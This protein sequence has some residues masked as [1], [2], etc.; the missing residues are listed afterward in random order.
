MPETISN[1]RIRY[2]NGSNSR[3]YGERYVH[4]KDINQTD[5][6][7]VLWHKLKKKKEICQSY[8]SRKYRTS[9]AIFCFTIFSW[10]NPRHW[11]PPPH[12]KSLL[13]KLNK[14]NEKEQMVRWVTIQLD[15]F[16]IWIFISVNNLKVLCCW[17]WC[18]MFLPINIILL[19]YELHF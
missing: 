12:G 18:K 4:F 7:L 19:S 9:E 5:N 2:C 1:I 13:F 6:S 14:S 16:E 3:Q 10:L 11:H 17:I 15:Y 8:K